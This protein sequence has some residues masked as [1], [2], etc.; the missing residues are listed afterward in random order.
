MLEA[1]SVVALGKLRIHTGDDR[2]A[3]EV[4]R[5]AEVMLTASAPGVQCHAAWYLALHAMYEGNPESAHRWLCARGGQER[6]AL[7]PL[8]PFEAVDDPQLV[9]MAVAVEDDELAKSTVVMAER[10]SELNPQVRSLA[11]VAAHARG[12][13]A[14]SIDDLER[15]TILFDETLRPLA[16]ASALEDLGRLKM[17]DGAVADAAAAF[18]RALSIATTAGALWDAARVR[19]RLRKLGV[20]RRPLSASRPK[21]GWK[22]LS[23]TELAVAQLAADGRTN[24]EIAEKLFISPHTVNTHLRHLFEKL[25]VNSRLALSRIVEDRQPPTS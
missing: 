10:R 18:D 9:R 25:G 12:L 22:A 19:R 15:A 11:A 17:G 14:K 2:G 24:R 1:P 6:L 13:W 16:L 7:F 21:S 5:I 8:F 23:A 20:R 3:N 4:A